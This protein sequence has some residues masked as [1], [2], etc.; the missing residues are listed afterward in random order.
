MKATKQIAAFRSVVVSMRRFFGIGFTPKKDIVSGLDIGR[1]NLLVEALKVFPFWQFAG[2]L[3]ILHHKSMLVRFVA[4]SPYLGPRMK[5]RDHN[6]STTAL[7][8][9]SR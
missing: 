9:N 3:Y 2:L 1:R 5:L 6:F 4:S 8:D 7:A